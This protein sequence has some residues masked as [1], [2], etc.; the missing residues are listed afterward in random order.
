MAESKCEACHARKVGGD[1]TGIYTRPDR[2]VKTKARVA[3]QVALCNTE[4]NL[5]LFPDDEAAITAFLND[6]Y[7]KY[8]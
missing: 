5:G 3:G 2:K 4:L 6:T 7:Y 8:K 1:G